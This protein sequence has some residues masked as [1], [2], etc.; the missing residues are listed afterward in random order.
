[1]LMLK[2]QKAKVKLREYEVPEAEWPSF[3]LNYRDLAYPTVLT[4]SQ[5]AEA[6]NDE[7]DNVVT[8]KSLKYCSEFYDAALQA[9]EQII[10]DAD[11]ALSGA[12]AYFFMDNYGSS[13]V[14][15]QEVDASQIIEETQRCLYDVFSLAFTGKMN[16]NIESTITHAIVL[17]WGNGDRNALVNAIKK[18]RESVYNMN[19]P[20]AL[21]WGE[22]VCAVVRIIANTSARIL[23]PYYSAL[24]NNQWEKYFNKKSAINLL[25][26]SQRLVGASEILKGKNAIIQLPTGVGKT[27]SIELIIWSLFLSERG[28]K[29]LIVVPLRSLCNEISYDLRIAFPKEVSINQF[30]DVL[31]DD[32]L[33]ML[34]STEKLIHI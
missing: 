32:F 26:P 20:Q 24:E 28:S 2:Y 25:W 15:W 4:I 33:M 17:F 1:M 30:S 22:I 9:R 19:S 11:F 34:G 21:F 23:L 7:S 13:K 5:Y 12:A 14:L 16:S 3:P 29:A 27:K 8:Y 31:E 10:H 6:I 18:Y